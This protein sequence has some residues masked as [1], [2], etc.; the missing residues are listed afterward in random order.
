MSGLTCLIYANPVYISIF[1]LVSRF[2]L[3]VRATMPVTVMYIRGYHSVFQ[4][5]VG[6]T[7]GCFIISGNILHDRTNR[8]CS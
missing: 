8:P 5:P 6:Y 4:P 3:Q 2:P 7:M 1:F